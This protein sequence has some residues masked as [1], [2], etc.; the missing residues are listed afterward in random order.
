MVCDTPSSQDAFTHKILNSYLKEYRTYAADS[1]QFLETRLEV[2]FKVT[3]TQFWYATLCRPKM[4]PHTK[5][6][7]PTPN[8]IRYMLQ[9][10]LY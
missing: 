6:E 4:H 2:K 1:M 7:I 9:T 8:N 3:V 5:Y 10:R